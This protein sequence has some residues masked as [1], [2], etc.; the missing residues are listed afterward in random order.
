MGDQG[1]TRPMHI[2]SQTCRGTLLLPPAASIVVNISGSWQTNS[3]VRRGTP[4]ISYS[5]P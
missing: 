1:V 3:N 4:W 2:P 5:L